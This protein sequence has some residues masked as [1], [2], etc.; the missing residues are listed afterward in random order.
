MSASA[1]SPQ[2]AAG[3]IIGVITVTNT[4]SGTCTALGYPTLALYGSG[5]APLTTT[6]VNGLS[7]TY[8]QLPKANAAPATTTI[9][10]SATAQFAYQF[11]D[12]PTAGETSCPTSVSASVTIPGASTASANFPLGI[13]PCNHGTIRLSPLFSTG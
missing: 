10:P 1:G 2:G 11:S 7:V 5:G 8:P 4:G 3:T 12:V 9:G 13:A 6:I